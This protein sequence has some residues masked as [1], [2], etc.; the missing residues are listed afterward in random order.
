VTVTRKVGA[1]LLL[2]TFGSLVGILTFAIFLERS[3]L[4]FLYLVTAT[5]EERLLQQL[6]VNSI[7]IGDGHVEI[8]WA[9]QR[10]IR[11]FDALLN[12]LEN[13]G[14][15]PSRMTPFELMERLETAASYPG[16]TLES[17]SPEVIRLL[18]DVI[19]P[20]PEEL[21]EKIST[22]R[23]EWLHLKNAFSAAA[24][25]DISDK[26]A[27]SSSALIRETM[28]VISQASRKMAS[29][30]GARLMERRKTMLITL[31]SIAGLSILLFAAGLLFTRNFITR[32][33]KSL[34]SASERIGSGDFSHRVPEL[35]GGSSDELVALGKTF[36]R[37]ADQV[38][39]SV[40]R[41]RELFENAADFVYTADLN[42]RFLT[43]NRAAETIS[44]YSREELLQKSFID[45]MPPADFDAGRQKQALL[46]SEAI[47]S[48]HEIHILSKDGKRVS[49]EDS[50]RPIYENGTL[51]GIQG[52]ARDVTE[53]NRLKEKLDLAQKME[54]LGRLAGGIAHDFA[55]VLT[56]IT[57]YCTLIDK[58]MK[59]DDP[60]RAEVKGIQR[61]SERATSM[62]RQLLAFSR[63]KVITPK[64]L[65]VDKAISEMAGGLRRL[66]G[67]NIQVLIGVTPSLAQVH[68]DPTQFEQVVT[69]LVLNARD[70]MPDG[71]EIRIEATN[72]DL[73][74]PEVNN[75]GGLP[76]GPYVRLKIADTG[77]GMPPEVLSR[78]FEPFFSTKKQ[79]TGL[80]LATVYSM[81]RQSGGQI[82]A[83]SQQ[84]VG[85]TMTIYLP[86][87]IEVPKA[88][89]AIS[90][91]TPT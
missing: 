62:I 83:E 86:R 41:Y 74:A 3:S 44:K 29:A 85:T 80:G 19:P 40:E 87:A 70:S 33:I 45:L 59:A 71:G 67:E 48:V 21:R 39:L 61:A 42:G 16:S 7:M 58:S 49:L 60:L 11:S 57:G 82:S 65:T 73:V 27:E 43:V 50:R 26:D 90:I 69:N 23:G 28:P 53:R 35:S 68:M 15:N 88:A 10:L 36:N 72:E 4:D 25:G 32:P 55:N 64:V 1:L 51:V 75:E 17:V 63:G 89:K 84:G 79:G 56:M 52:V 20:P 91:G 2:L 8:R 81:V 38:Q 6:Y 14:P 47:K 22:V 9:Q 76:S 54:A 78:I 34:R 13:G 5:H 66:T 24:E 37:M 77:C 12:S 31:A 30:A 18:T 46:S